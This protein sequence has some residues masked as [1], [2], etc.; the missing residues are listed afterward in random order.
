[1]KVR[2][3]AIA[4]G[5]E[6]TPD[7]FR[8]DR[9]A[10]VAHYTDTGFL[11]AVGYPMR[12]GQIHHSHSRRGAVRGVHYED[13]PPGQ[14]KVVSCAAGALLDVVVDLRVGS[15]TFGHW[16]SV[17]L[18]P[19]TCR[20]VY[21]EEGLGHGYVALQDDTVA[22][23]VSSVEYD[24]AAEHEIHPLDPRLG[25]PWPTDMAYLLSERDRNAPTLTEA[26]DAGRLPTY[27]ACRALHRDRRPLVPTYRRD[28]GER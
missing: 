8:D 12:L 1:M 10:F 5:Y 22:A 26:R 24:P 4:G 17:L 11:D 14:A 9:G 15:P 20:A 21:L 28:H 27:E 16:D 2:E 6:F 25:L 7:V 23:Y 3:L 13:V 18:D 19:H